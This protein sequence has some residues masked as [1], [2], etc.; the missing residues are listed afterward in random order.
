M[1]ISHPYLIIGK[2]NKFLKP[3]IKKADVWRKKMIPIFVK[4]IIKSG[5]V[6]LAEIGR[7]TK[8][9]CQK[10][11]TI[12]NILSR[13]L[14]STSW[15]EE[16]LSDEYLRNVSRWVKKDTLIIVDPSERIKPYGEKLENLAYVRDGSS[17]ELFPGYWT[18]E[19]VAI[20]GDQIRY[21]L[22]KLFSVEDQATP[23]FPGTIQYYLEGIIEATKGVGI[24]VLDRGF[25]SDD[26]FNFYQS[27]QTKMVVRLTGNRTVCDLEGKAIGVIEQFAKK[28]RLG[29]L[30]KYSI[31]NKVFWREFTWLKVTMPDVSG[32]FTLV[33][34]QEGNEWAY[35]LTN[36]EVSTSWE[37]ERILRYYE[38]HPQVDQ[39][40]RLLKQTTK[41]EHFLVRS[42]LAIKR[43]N[44]LAFLVCAFILSQGTLSPVVLRWLERLGK[45]FKLKVEFIYYRIFYG[46][47]SLFRLITPF[48]LRGYAKA[49]G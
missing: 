20:N 22:S 33:I 36:L 28:M 47:Q 35:F 10:M 16:I 3:V 6:H 4:G 13:H 34:S 5:S 8:R 37:A 41:I 23:S 48:S 17:G 32:Y 1:R 12:E 40:I 44:F 25:D 24:H 26:Y 18:L 19:V 43:I 49:G 46:I 45:C 7:Q 29:Y 21:L 42:Y 31:G 2:L 30:M 38:Y 9:S 11:K 39:V 15:D 14:N 27:H